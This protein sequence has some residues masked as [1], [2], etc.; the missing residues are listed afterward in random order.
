MSDNFQNLRKTVNSLIQEFQ[1]PT[2]PKHFIIKSF[3]IGDEEKAKMKQLGKRCVI[4][5]EAKTADVL[6]ETG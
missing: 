6:L 3:K 2:D 4:Y 1:S 5:R